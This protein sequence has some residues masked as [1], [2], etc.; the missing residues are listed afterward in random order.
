MNRAIAIFAAGLLSASA[1]LDA[2]VQAQSAPPTLS[3]AQQD[4]LSKLQLS[5][6]WTLQT[7]LTALP[8]PRPALL[9]EL[10]SYQQQQSQIQPPTPQQTRARQQLQYMLQQLSAQGKTVT[11]DIVGQAN[12]LLQQGQGAK[13]QIAGMPLPQL[14]ANLLD[15]VAANQGNADIYA[16]LAL[17]Q[18]YAQEMRNTAREQRSGTMEAQVQAMQDAAEK[19]K[20]AAAANMQQAQITGAMQ[21]AA[22]MTQLGAAGAMGQAKPGQPQTAIKSPTANGA[23]NGAAAGIG[24]PAKALTAQEKQQAIGSLATTQQ[25]FAASMAG[26]EADKKKAEAAA[27]T[28]QAQA[29]T[30][31]QTQA[32]QQMQQM[33]EIIRDI[34]QKLQAIQQSQTAAAQAILRN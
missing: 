4:A 22:G 19:M 6:L 16:F 29:Q 13:T 14:P 8:S 15:A 25:S 20:Q 18:K 5:E 30:A 17:F 32:Q 31:Q 3:A 34:Q 7:I 10:A 28:A 11:G 33:Q 9:T 21:I 12:L 2:P 1:A 26:V 23:A 24:V 27:T